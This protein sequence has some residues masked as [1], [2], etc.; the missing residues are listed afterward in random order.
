MNDA[1][2]IMKKF[3]NLYNMSPSSRKAFTDSFAN[4]ILDSYNAKPKSLS[5]K[6]DKATSEAFKT[7]DRQKYEKAEQAFYQG[8]DELMK[9]REKLTEM[10][11]KFI[12][13]K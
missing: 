10:Y 5:D 3:G 7:G 8:R 12:K 13:V 6:R 4:G 9:M 11:G 1:E 2:N